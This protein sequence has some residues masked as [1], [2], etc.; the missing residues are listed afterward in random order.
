VPARV[1]LEV[2]AIV[3]SVLGFARRFLEQDKV[4]VPVGSGFFPAAWL[5]EAIPPSTLSKL[6]KS[7]AAFESATVKGDPALRELLAERLRTASIPAAAADLIITSGASHAFDLIARTLLAP[8]D[9]VLVND[10][11]FF[12]LHA[13]LRALNLRLIPVPML[14]D[15]SDLE[16][17]ESA[18]RLHRPRM[19]FTQSLLQNPTGSSSSAANCHQVLKLA[20]RYDFLVTEDHMLSDLAGAGAVTLAQI[21]ELRRVIYVGSFTKLLGP[22]LRIGYIAAQS[23]LIAPIIKAKVLNLLAGSA[24][25]E[26][27]VREVLASGKYR[28]HIVHLR[29]RVAKARAVSVFQLRQVGLIIESSSS[30]GIFLWARIPPGMDPDRLVIAA[31]A[32]GILL[33]KG[34]LFSPTGQCRGY[35]RL[36]VAYAADP[37]LLSFLSEQFSAAA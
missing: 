22:G 26:S 36:N 15:G 18:A 3:D 2:S 5:E 4:I 25:C 27:V 30:E 29:D 7:G 6:G 32:Q 1:E 24:L 21:D 37:L 17:L 9:A 31:Q 33:A 34:S 35:F 12:V 19:F 28:R 8:G 13:Q 11:S 23:S 20:E 16:A 10:P 14:A